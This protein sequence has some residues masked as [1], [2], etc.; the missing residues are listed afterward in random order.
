LPHDDLDFW[1][2][3]EYVQRD[4]GSYEAAAYNGEELLGE[5]VG[6]TKQEAVRAA[7]QTLGEQIASDLT[8]KVAG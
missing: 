8:E 2:T 7:L 5:G 1:V 4:D 6:D 3:V